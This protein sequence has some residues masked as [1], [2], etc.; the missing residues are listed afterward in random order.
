[1]PLKNIDEFK[2]TLPYAS[3]L[4]GVYMPLLGWK[5]SRTAGRVESETE[6]SIRIL[7]RSIMDYLRLS[8]YIPPG[9]E[10]SWRNALKHVEDVV[11]NFTLENKRF[12]KTKE[13]WAGIFQ[14][15]KDNLS[16]GK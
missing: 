7:V 14:K 4:F 2:T 11:V 5:G 13:D 6:R 15:A 16:A 10:F 1:L 3:E 9:T 8:V 12:P